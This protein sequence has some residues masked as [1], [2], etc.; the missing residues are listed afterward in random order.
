LEG[1]F[2]GLMPKSTKKPCAKTVLSWL[3]DPKKKIRLDHGRTEKL[4]KLLRDEY[5]HPEK[6]NEQTMEAVLKRP[7]VLDIFDS[8]E[9]ESIS[10]PRQHSMLSSENSEWNTTELTQSQ[11]EFFSRIQKYPELTFPA[12]STTPLISLKHGTPMRQRFKPL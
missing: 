1:S 4:L 3:K 9:S 12:H 8:H 6:M 5:A 7:Q 11:A 2:S 10:A